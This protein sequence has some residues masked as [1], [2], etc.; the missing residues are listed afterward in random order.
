MICL[1]ALVGLIDQE[2]IIGSGI[3]PLH[4]VPKAL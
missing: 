4:T 3:L 2:M 1:K